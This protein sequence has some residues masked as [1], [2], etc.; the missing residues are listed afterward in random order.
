MIATAIYLHCNIAKLYL[1]ILLLLVRGAITILKMTEFI[2][3]K[4]DIPYIMENMYVYIYMKILVN[5]NYVWDI[6]LYG[7]YKT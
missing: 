4:D 1:Y 6:C 3:G 2:N 5:I 7:K